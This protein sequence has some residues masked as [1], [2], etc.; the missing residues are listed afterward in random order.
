MRLGARLLLAVL[1]MTALSGCSREELN[2]R[3]IEVHGGKV[4]KVFRF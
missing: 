1:A 3:G 4:E 2:Q